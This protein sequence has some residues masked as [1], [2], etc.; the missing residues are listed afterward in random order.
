MEVKGA[1]V[2][3]LT[4]DELKWSLSRPGRFTDWWSPGYVFSR[5]QNAPSEPLRSRERPFPLLEVEPRFPECAAVCSVVSVMTCA[6]R[7][8]DLKLRA[9]FVRLI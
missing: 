2:L 7:E 5:R 6:L 9:G 3:T 1:R 8:P 4:L